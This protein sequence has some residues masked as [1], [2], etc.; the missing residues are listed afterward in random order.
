[1]GKLLWT[2]RGYTTEGGNKIVQNWF[3]F[4]LSEDER[5]LIR[6]RV[7]YLKDLERHLW[8]EPGFKK[9]DKD[10]SEIRKNTPSGAIRIYGNFPAE[11]HTFTLLHGDYKKVSNDKTG[12]SKAKERL[13][14]LEQRKG[15]THE[16]DFQ[17]K[18]GPDDSKGKKDKIELS[19]IKLI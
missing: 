6:V 1:M 11:R 13:K 3:D 12:K 10:L 5:D 9:L 19:R 7:N 4:T 18:P 16:F 8:K 15:S 17:E 2:F 14:L